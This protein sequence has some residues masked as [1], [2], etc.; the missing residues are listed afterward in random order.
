MG[1]PL[2][3]PNGTIGVIVVQDYDNPN[4]Y[5][6]RDRDFLALIGSQVALAIERKQAE[7]ALRQSEN[8]YSLASK[9]TNDVIWEWEQETNQLFWNENALCRIWIRS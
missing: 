9:A 8:R 5:T 1:A 7:K 6:E 4:R 3:T 2:K